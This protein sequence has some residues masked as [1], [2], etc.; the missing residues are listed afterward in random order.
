MS[1]AKY[2]VA[3]GS[4]DG[5]SSEGSEEDEAEKEDDVQ[6][7]SAK[8]NVPN[9]L[10]G[11]ASSR[12]V[13]GSEHLWSTQLA[14]QCTFGDLGQSPDGV[15][16]E[17]S[18]N[19]HLFSPSM[20]ASPPVLHY[21]STMRSGL[22]SAGS[23]SSSS[24]LGQVGSTA[25]GTYSRDG[26]AR[27]L[28]HGAQK[29]RHLE[30]LND[31][32]GVCSSSC[33]CTGVLSPN[34]VK[35]CHEYSYGPPQTPYPAKRTHEAWLDLIDSF[36]TYD[37]D[38]KP[39]ASYKVAGYACCAVVTRMAYGITES[40]WNALHALARK[41]PGALLAAKQTGEW[42][43]EA[44]RA[45]QAE[46][47]SSTSEARTW[48]VDLLKCMCI[49]PNEPTIQHHP[50]FVFS[51]AYHDLYLPEMELFSNAPALRNLKK[52]TVPPSS[53]WVAQ[54]EALHVVSLEQY[55]AK[56]DDP[57]SPKE[58]Y[59]LRERPNHSNFPECTGCS[60]RRARVTEALA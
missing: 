12:D 42:D 14:T 46:K 55:G 58:L 24:R 38:S 51:R 28:T 57:N 35:Q 5:S 8:T 47:V 39:S 30:T 3:F 49:M 33:G 21:E 23:S 59:K 56:A 10:Q 2:S 50:D 26:A 11:A 18:D 60:E 6:Q 37:S 13:G 43:R 15:A 52:A 36:F 40:K 45:R 48:W 54:K 9:W 1:A 25:R 17:A 27:R 4:D 53:W 7:K 19:A 16:K 44:R 34:V 29:K 41:G 20:V 32:F 31:V 22:S